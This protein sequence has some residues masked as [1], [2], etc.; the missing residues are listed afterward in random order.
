MFHLTPAEFWAITPHEFSLMV[1]GRR[2]ELDRQRRFAA[3]WISPLLSAMAGQVISEAELLGE[4][5]PVADQAQKIKLAQKRL[6]K[7]QKDMAKAG[8]Q[9]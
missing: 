9:S 8:A 6:A 1:E 2:D 5:D 3:R 4:T 7:M